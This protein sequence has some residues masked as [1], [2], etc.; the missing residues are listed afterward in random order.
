MAIVT[1]NFFYK[2]IIDNNITNKNASILICGG[3]LFDK[4]LLSLEPWIKINSN[5]HRF[6]TDWVKKNVID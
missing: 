6:N 5:K 1:R 2:R 4:S 3:G